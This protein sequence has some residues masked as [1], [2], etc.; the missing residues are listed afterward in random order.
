[1]VKKKELRQQQIEKMQQLD[2]TT[3]KQYEHDLYDQLFADPDFQAA[4]S[5]GV[6]YSNVFEINT[7]PIIK[8]A[9]QQGKLVYLPRTN[10]EGH[11]MNFIQYAKGDKLE[12][13]KFG[14]LEPLENP[15]STN[16]YLD[17]IIVPG[18]GYTSYPHW[19][20]GFGGGYYDRFLAKYPATTISLA[21]PFMAFESPEWTTYPHDRLI[22]RVLVAKGS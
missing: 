1:M 17:L 6:T 16:N 15:E 21:F 7:L 13:S 3:R 2:R 10:P 11:Q 5:I 4:D 12:R 18:L 8:E 22:N 20:V 9:W 14:V 19:R